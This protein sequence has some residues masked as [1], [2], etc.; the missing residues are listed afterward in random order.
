MRVGPWD[1]EDI[2]QDALLLF[3]EKRDSIQPRAWRA[4]ILGTLRNRE[5]ELFKKQALWR[6]YE[7]LLETHRQ[8]H[9]PWCAEPDVALR[10][11]EILLAL[12]WL[13]SQVEPS[14][15]DVAERHLFDGLSL[16]A[17]AEETH[18]PLGTVRSRWARARKDM[19]AAIER[20]R[21]E[22][23]DAFVAVMIALLGA[24][25]L[26]IVARVRRTT[27]VVV[28]TARR[29]LR[30][31]SGPRAARGRR[32]A[33]SRTGRRRFAA[34]VAC[35]LLPIAAANHAASE[36]SSGAAATIDANDVPHEDGP[37]R[38]REILPL[39]PFLTT[40]AEREREWTPLVDASIRSSS[41]ASAA[42]GRSSSTA[43]AAAGRS[44]PTVPST[45]SEHERGR[46]LHERARAA[47]REDHEDMARDAL[48]LY[49]E[50]FPHDPFPA[51]R[52]Q[53]ASALVERS[54]P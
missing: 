9:G 36:S 53:V 23:D 28:A 54:E 4:W 19:R 8:D 10:Q 50:D 42:A 41:T 34:A 16:E 18:A 48:R 52:A 1:A 20:E 3:V 22:L 38:A 43:P 45:T 24:W 39:T 5:R 6:K 44:T 2:L 33:R 29:R 51:L 26:W 17:I 47:L 46:G 7:P 14:R 13:R 30:R 12:I 35:A 11:R 49:D 21:E 40:N 32:T 25:T 15:R 31:P 37:G 27:H